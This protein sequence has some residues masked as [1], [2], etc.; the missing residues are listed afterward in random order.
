MAIPS[1]DLIVCKACGACAP[2]HH[3]LKVYCGPCARKLQVEYQRRYRER[4]KSKPRLIQCKGCGKQFDVSQTGRA[5][6]CPECLLAYQRE[7]AK[8]RKPRLAGYSR[9]YRAKLGDKYNA[10]L[11]R[12]RAEKIAQMTPAQ[13][14][15]FRQQESDKTARLNAILKRDVF[16]AYGGYVCRCCGEMEPKFLS[17]DHINNDGAEMRKSGK[18]SR[19]GVAFYQWLRKSGFPKGFQVLC[20]NCNMGKHR[21]G[22]VCPHQSGN[23]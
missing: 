18:H 6:R 16:N 10:R 5:W 9:K 15:E 20:M 14:A 13:L 7:Y 3:R 19:G 11:V 1:E 12:Q 4:Q 23:V 17:I 21:N 2:P 22:G 8:T